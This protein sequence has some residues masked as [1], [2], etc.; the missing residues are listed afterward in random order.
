MNTTQNDIATLA[1]ITKKNP[2]TEDLHRGFL[3]QMRERAGKRYADAVSELRASIVD[4]ASVENVLADDPK[5]PE[6]IRHERTFSSFQPDA[7][8][9]LRHQGFVPSAPSRIRDDVKIAANKL[10]AAC[11]A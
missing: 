8:P 1:D 3:S 7:L 2:R 6:N 5:V 9:E 11:K 4:L 10:R